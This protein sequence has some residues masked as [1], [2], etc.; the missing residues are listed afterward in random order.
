MKSLI[1]CF[2]TILFLLP[3][4]IQ[5]QPPELRW[6]E[7]YGG[8]RD[9][10]LWCLIQT[11]DDNFAISGNTFSFGAGSN[12]LWLVRVDE[13][14][15]MLEGWPRTYGGNQGE[16]GGDV[17]KVEEGF[18][19]GG[20]TWSWG[21]QGGPDFLLVRIEEDGDIIGTQT[22]GSEL[23]EGAQY[24]VIPLIQTLNGGF[25][26]GG[27]RQVRYDEGISWD[28]VIILTD[29]N[30]ENPRDYGFGTF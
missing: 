26:I 17:I 11:P 8:N 18:I 25:G 16:W 21:H 29:E 15:E 6:E 5:A 30:G 13:D 24:L 14:G 12:D 22:Y 9:E 10:W 19:L 20:M 1:V 23:W 7:T 27:V 4:F 3:S 2:L 28:A